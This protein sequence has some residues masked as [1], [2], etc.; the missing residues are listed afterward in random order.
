MPA[1]AVE[2]LELTQHPEV[3]L[4]QIARVVTRDPALAAKVLKTVN[5]SFY[6]CSH[7][8]STINH[9]LVILGLQS[10][11]TLVLGFS[12]VATLKSDK[13]VYFDRQK[14][15]RRSMFAATA[16]RVIS[17]RVGVIQVEEAFLSTLLS[18]IGQL[19]LDR[20]VGEQYAQVT[21]S[22]NSHH[23]LSALEAEQLGAT[24]AEVGALIAEMWKLPVLLAA[25]IAYHHK[26]DMTPEQTIKPIIDVVHAAS[27]CADVFCE[28]PAAPAIHRARTTLAAKF[29]MQPEAVD[30]LLSEVTAQTREFAKLFE[31]SLNG[32]ANDYP[33]ILKRANDAL[34]EISLQ[35]HTQ[36]KQ[37]EQQNQILQVKATVDKLT[38]LV[39]RGEFDALLD[40]AFKQAN[41]TGKS[42][43][44]VMIDVD[45]FKLI[46]DTHG[47]DV[48]DSTLK[49]LAQLV[50]NLIRPDDIAAR[51]GG[52]EIALICAN[53]QR[54]VAAAIAETIRRAIAAR[55]VP[56]GYTAVSVHAS[57]GV[58]THDPSAGFKDVA[59]LLKAA[60]LAMYKA[61][62]CGRNCVKVFAHALKAA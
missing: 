8:V 17:Q 23:D 44:V 55:P 18:D 13:G 16:A 22:V 35:G 1:V 19:V 15:W 31:I 28:E 57:L 36:V 7:A 51:L 4:K 14:Y 11:K 34:V 40:A 62:N 5:S 38:G 2:V 37:L 48:G 46:N 27:A 29:A 52:D 56:A 12:L 59:Q 45:Q 6:G 54:P 32:S 21:S 43:S 53:A 47:H 24:H 58:A 49:Y 26:P 10:V 42:L 9:A 30:Q 60:D 33:A 50:K 41:S 61:K 25:P 20:V 3:D 39:N